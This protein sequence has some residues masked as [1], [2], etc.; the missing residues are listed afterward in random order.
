MHRHADRTTLVG[1][2]TRH[3]LAYPPR[4]VSRELEAALILEFLDR[5]HQAPIAF[6]DKVEKGEPAVDVSLGKAH[7][8]S[9]IGFGQLLLSA[10]AL[11]LTRCD[12]FDRV[13][14]SRRS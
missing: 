10:P 2:R 1:N 4:R 5:A 3:R 7:Y 13:R 11:V 8:Q 6:L 12:G 14:Q 9:Q